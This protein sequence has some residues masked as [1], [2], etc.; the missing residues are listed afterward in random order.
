MPKRSPKVLLISTTVALALVAAMSVPAA[1]QR[2][3]AQQGSG[4]Q[5]MQQCVAGVLAR[6]AKAQ[7]PETQVGPTVISQCD[8][9]L[10]ASL[11][12]A[13][14]TGEAAGCTIETCLDMARAR[15]AQESTM[16]YRQRGGR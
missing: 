9:Q 1:A 13:I 15:A 5:A 2:A 11:A 16:A 14:R 8:R 7:A 4:R 12:D 3:G 10:R 6:L